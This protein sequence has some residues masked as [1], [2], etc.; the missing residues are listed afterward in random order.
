MSFSPFVWRCVAYL[1]PDAVPITAR[2]QDVTPRKR[3]YTRLHWIRKTGI[4]LSRMNT[5]VLKRS[6]A[7]VL[8]YIGV[9]V[10]I[11]LIQFSQSPGF[12]ARFG[13]LS[14]SASY[15]TA[16]RKTP[17]S[18]VRIDFAGLELELS[19]EKPA[20]LVAAD[21]SVTKILPAAIE[22]TSTGV[23][24][25]FEGGTELRIASGAQGGM[26]LSANNPQSNGTNPRPD[27]RFTGPR[28]YRRAFGLLDSRRPRRSL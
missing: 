22:K 26:D 1:S 25:L 16:D 3:H 10:V 5:G 17:P 2:Q 8:L 7:L 23:R 13:R 20:A 4:F 24:I 21:G 6:L 27:L 9:F 18:S 14:V 11:V 12:S 28:E 15:P 19:A